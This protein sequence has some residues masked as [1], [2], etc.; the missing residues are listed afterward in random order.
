MG[1]LSKEWHKEIFV[2]DN[3]LAFMYGCATSESRQSKHELPLLVFGRRGL[4]DWCLA[5]LIS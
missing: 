5:V 3:S 2:S 1:L 4:M